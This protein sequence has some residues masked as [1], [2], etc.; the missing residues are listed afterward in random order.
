M[1]LWRDMFIT[2]ARNLQPSTEQRCHP[3]SEMENLLIFL[4]VTKRMIQVKQHRECSA[5]TLVVWGIG[6]IHHNGDPGAAVF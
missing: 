2:V 3:V 1:V 5:D 6:C 4:F